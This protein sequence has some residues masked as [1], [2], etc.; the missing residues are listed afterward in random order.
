MLKK[1]INY[2]F[3]IY[4]AFFTHRYLFPVIQIV[5][6]FLFIMIYNIYLVASHYS[7]INAYV[8]KNVTN[9]IVVM[10]IL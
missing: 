4:L 7:H 1:I 6:P 10:V 2:T 5:Q 8:L 3:L 9:Q